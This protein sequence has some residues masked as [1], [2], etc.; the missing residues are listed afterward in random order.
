MAQAAPQ[1]IYTDLRRQVGSLLSR[2]SS[3]PFELRRLSADIDKLTPIDPM[4]AL[5]IK[6]TVAA[7]QGEQDVS[8]QLFDRLLQVTGGE[9]RF[10]LRAIQVA[11]ISGQS[12]RLKNLYDNFL[13][14]HELPVAWKREMG[15]LLGFNGWFRESTRLQSELQESGEDPGTK[16]A[17]S[18]TFPSELIDDHCFDAYPVFVSKTTTTN[19]LDANEVDDEEVAK[20]FSKAIS[21]LRAWQLPPSG[22]RTVN[23][24]HDDSTSGVLVSFMVKGACEEVADAEW[25]LFGELA[26]DAPQSLLDGVI[27]V[28]VLACQGEAGGN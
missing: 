14:G 18:L 7:V 21:L 25:N 6:A 8:A 24:V 26:N 9:A 17:K 27:S 4:G 22:A 2:A 20:L 5:E 28:G 15:Q 12:F 10:L 16:E 11:A 19:I 13:V 3:S 23:L 1:T